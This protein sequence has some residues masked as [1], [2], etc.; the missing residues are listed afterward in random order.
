[1]TRTLH[2]NVTTAVNGVIQRAVADAANV[3]RPSM[4]ENP[5]SPSF[6]YLILVPGQPAIFSARTWLDSDLAKRIGEVV[7]KEH[8]GGKLIHTV[9]YKPQFQKES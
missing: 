4:N 8:P 5:E 9:N 3:P 2:S 1:M 7:V 6:G